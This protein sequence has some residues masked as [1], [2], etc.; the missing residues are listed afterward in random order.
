MADKAIILA[1]FDNQ[2]VLLQRLTLPGKAPSSLVEMQLSACN[3]CSES[4]L[5][6]QHVLLPVLRSIKRTLWHQYG[7]SASG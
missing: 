3:S 6:K 7:M 2:F 5:W 4:D 1:C